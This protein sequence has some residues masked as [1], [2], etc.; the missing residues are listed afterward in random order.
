IA[1][2]AILLI[3]MFLPESKRVITYLLSLAALV[4]CAVLTFTDLNTGATVYT[5]NNMFV[6]DPLANLLKLFTY[7][8]VGV[9]LIYSRQYNT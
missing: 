2:S 9:T 1:T 8:G 7:L 5:F 4:V 6:S 3:D